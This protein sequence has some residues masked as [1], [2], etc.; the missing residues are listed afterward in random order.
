MIGRSARGRPWFLAHV[1]HFLK[2]GQRLEPPPLTFQL[3]IA[4]NNF[5]TMLSYYGVKRGIR[6]ARKH[7]NWYTAA[8]SRKD[9]YRDQLLKSDEPNRIRESLYELFHLELD[10]FGSDTVLA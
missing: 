5:D 10:A 8:F 2:N 4:F 7:L 3:D 1:I 9:V 6:I